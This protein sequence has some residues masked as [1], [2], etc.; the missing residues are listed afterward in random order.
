MM[1]AGEVHSA[2][3]IPC[4]QITQTHTLNIYLQRTYEENEF[5][6]KLEIMYNINK[7]NI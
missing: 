3:S 5:Q 2:Y 7:I 6:D 4:Q 1:A